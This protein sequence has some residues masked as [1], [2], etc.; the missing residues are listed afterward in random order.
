MYLWYHIMTIL[1][2]RRIHW[3]V[4]WF[5]VLILSSHYKSLWKTKKFLKNTR[6]CKE[7]LWNSTYSFDPNSTLLLDNILT[8]R[9]VVVLTYNNLIKISAKHERDIVFQITNFAF[10][11]FFTIKNWKRDIELNIH[12]QA[13]IILKQ[14]S[15]C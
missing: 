5:S 11:S 7:E 4:I 6:S 12:N 3:S 2:N 13:Y 14:R 10:I 9:K 1:I 15:K 8:N